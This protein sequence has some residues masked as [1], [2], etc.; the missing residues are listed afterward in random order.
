MHLKISSLIN[1]FSVKEISNTTAGTSFSKTVFPISKIFVPEDKPVCQLPVTHHVSL[2][3]LRLKATV[4][5]ILCKFFLSCDPIPVVSP[6]DVVNVNVKFT[7]LR[8]R[9]HVFKYLFCPL[10]VSVLKTPTFLTVN[11]VS[12]PNV[13]NLISRVNPT[14]RLCKATQYTHTALVNNPAN[15][16]Y[17]C[18]ERIS[19]FFNHVQV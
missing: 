2:I 3:L 4:N 8:P 9:V 11:K 19:C 15:I 18:H 14:H 5:H 13:C 17:L 16:F 10:R 12:P 1:A 6:V 7:P